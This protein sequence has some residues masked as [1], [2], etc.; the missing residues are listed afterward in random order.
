MIMTSKRLASL[1]STGVMVV[2]AGVMLI[3]CKSNQA[4]RSATN[5]SQEYTYTSQTF[6]VSYTSALN[7]S[8][9]LMLGMLRLEGT[10]NAITAE[11]ATTLLPV[12]QALQGQVLKSDA[13]RNAVWAYIEAHLTPAQSSA[14][15]NMHLTQ[16]DL[17][18]W[19]RDSGPGAGFGPGQGGAGLQ[20]TP[21]AF[22]RQSAGP[23]GT[24]GAFPG[25][26]DVRPQGTPGVRQGQGGARLQGTPGTRS[27]FGGAAGSAG[28]ISGQS[29]MLLG[30][31]IR[32]LAQKSGGAAPSS[33]SRSMNQTPIAPQTRVSTTQTSQP[34]NVLTATPSPAAQPTITST[35]TATATLTPTT[36]R[37]AMSAPTQSPASGA[38]LEFTMDDIE[39]APSAPRM[40]DRYIQLTIRLKPKGGTSP[41]SLLLDGTTQVD[42]LTY[43]FDWHKC[44]ESEPHSVVVLSA[45]GQKSEPVGFIFPYQCP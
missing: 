29:N 26:G 19:T 42:G 9:Q 12:A 6:T 24:P 32:L 40:G 22:P 25:Q 44:G 37:R 16:D 4:A 15:A 28:A 39:Y 18:T 21:G 41:F 10:D 34:T 8:N 38:P 23:Q 30:A 31:L 7:A 3:G 33:G 2:L 45:D 13:E 17:Q 36:A 35:I 27:S 43:T 20:G 14:I 11:Q 5:N 1:C